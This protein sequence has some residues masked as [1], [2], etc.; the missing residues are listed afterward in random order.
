MSE[1]NDKLYDAS[2][3]KVLKGLEAVK[4]RPGMYTRTENPNHI[5][6][7]AIDNAQDEA[8]AGYATKIAIKV[9]NG[10]TIEIEDNGRGIP[11]DIVESEGRPALEVIFS[12]LH[13]GGKF[14]KESDGA[15]SFSGGLHGV[16]VSVTNALS[17]TLETRVKKDG[18]EYQ[19]IFNDGELVQPLKEIGKTLKRDTGTKIIATPDLKYFENKLNIEQLKN[20]LRVKSALLTGV[21]ISLQIDDEEPTIWNYKS[22]KEYLIAESTKANNETFWATDVAVEENLPDQTDFIW[23]FEKYLDDSSSGG[24]KGEGLQLVMGFLEEGKRVNESFVNLI[25]TLNGGTHERGLRNG[26][27]EGFKN[28][29]NHYSLTPKIAIESDDL[30][31][32][33]SFV[34]SSKILDPQF[35]GQTKEKLSSE[36]AAR[37]NVA[38]VKDAFELW[39]N[40]NLDFAK[41]L[42]DLVVISAQRRT[43][44][45]PKAERKKSASNTTLPGKLSDCEETNPELTEL[46]LVEGDSAAGSS[47]MGRNKD[48]QAI[49]PLRGKILNTWEVPVERLF[50]SSIIYDISV[51]IGVQPHDLD[52]N[53]D[54]SKLR[55]HKICIMCDAD[56]DGRH[57]E[58]L[59]ITLFLKHFPQL[60][61][62]GH[63]FV[64]KAPLFRIDYP[65]NKKNKSKLDKKV[66]IQ[67]NEDL[68][69]LMKK[70]NKEGFTEDNIKVSRFKGLGEMNPEQLWDTTL[71][72]ENRTLIQICI[73]IDH[74]EADN[75]IFTLLMSKKE[76]SKRRDWME[77]KGNTVEVDV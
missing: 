47:K 54:F 29:M 12:T 45:E 40:E 75:D 14:D 7:E 49:L 21:E 52:E 55:Y 25:P 63:L 74:L 58:V 41:R 22:L 30:W 13:S 66:Y 8:L 50:D 11:V 15:Y 9:I 16:G 73:D 3:I 24:K 65:S 38:L 27:F 68:E 71:D 76:A 69:V 36:S 17:K 10:E 64:A 33:A 31:Q 48:F 70:L 18:K 61:K 72:P 35:Q 37:L 57:I 60:I 34:L 20:Y 51:A 26:L 44:D 2:K 23:E 4:L 56:V 6:Y 5:I 32:R 67:T 53:V 42:V 1:N 62:K 59:L 19:V 39:L 77:E 28:F 46:F 43:K